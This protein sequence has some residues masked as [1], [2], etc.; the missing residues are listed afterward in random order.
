MSLKNINTIQNPNDIENISYFSNEYLYEA[1]S[2][3]GQRFSLKGDSVSTRFFTTLSVINKQQSDFSDSKLISKLS[4][5][6]N[7]L[8]LEFFDSKNINNP[9]YKEEL[10]YTIDNLFNTDTQIVLNTKINGID[11]YKENM[12]MYLDSNDNTFSIVSIGCDSEIG[13]VELNIDCYNIKTNMLISSIKLLD[14]NDDSYYIYYLESNETDDNYIALKYKCDKTSID[15]L[16]GS[17][18]KF[19]SEIYTIIK[20]YYNQYKTINST[21]IFNEII[22]NNENLYNKLYYII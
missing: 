11:Y 3:L 13:D 18:E 2:N 17:F 7:K 14:V 15:T 9:L 16:Y 8:Y 19:I 12:L 20:E 4:A 1:L 5:N 22:Y 21:D 6:K 10:K